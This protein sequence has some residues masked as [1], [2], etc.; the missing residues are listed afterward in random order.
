M[1]SIYSPQP[2]FQKA[3]MWLKDTG[4]LTKLKDDAMNPPMPIPLPKVRHNQPLILTQLGITMIILV[5]G[6]SMAI[7][8]FLAELW[9]TRKKTVAIE[10]FELSP[11]RAD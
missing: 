9:T 3:I 8:M 7:L 6:L 11:Q 1:C 4:I 5:V 2:D 10:H